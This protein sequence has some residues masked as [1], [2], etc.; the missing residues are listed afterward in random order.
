MRTFG[1]ERGAA[2]LTF[3]VLVNY[4]SCSEH[5]PPLPLYPED[6]KPVP[7]IIEHIN[8]YF[9]P[10]KTEYMAFE[11]IWVTFVV[12]NGG[13]EPF[14]IPDG[15]AYR[16]LGRDENFYVYIMGPKGLGVPLYRGNMGGLIGGPT[17]V[18]PHGRH[19][20]RMLLTA[21][22]DLHVPGTYTVTMRRELF[23]KPREVIEFLPSR[24]KRLLMPPHLRLSEDDVRRA[25][26][27]DTMKHAKDQN[28]SQE[29][30]LQDID[31][32]MRMPMIESTFQI[33]IL[34][35]NAE[36]FTKII[37]TLP[38]DSPS[39]YILGLQLGLPRDQI[40]RLNVERAL[41][42][43]AVPRSRPDDEGF[44]IWLT[45]TR[46]I[47]LLLEIPQPWP[48]P[49]WLTD[50]WEWLFDKEEAYKAR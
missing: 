34:P 2:W 32:M 37:E 9:A 47:Y 20:R 7:P 24:S 22:A 1:K 28:L 33:D 6:P 49:Q 25:L 21:W 19:E 50:R 11:P 48:V 12:T 43:G 8:G 41:R 16:S 18:P 44:R 10:D 42:D 40:S 26:V 46:E 39:S 45:E 17:M 29:E 4:T 13:D 23:A 15:G 30:I 27:R 31:W 36:A 14:G 38:L 3:C 5:E 35:F